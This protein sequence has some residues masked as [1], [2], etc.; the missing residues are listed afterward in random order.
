MRRS[1]RMTLAFLSPAILVASL[2]SCA[3][4]EKKSVPELPSRICWNVFASKDVTPLL[5]TGDKAMLRARPFVLAEELDSVT[6]SLDIDGAT[7][8]TA[9]ATLRDF[10]DQIDWAPIDEAKPAPINVGRKGI[11]WYDGAASY[12]VC[13]PAQSP[14]RPGRYVDLTISTDGS[15]DEEVLQKSL[16]TLMKQFVTFAQ[17]ELNCD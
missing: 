4:S 12:I 14:S 13:E 17:R 15:P 8:F 2:T 3:D 16:P 5:P 6:C 9:Y 11:I 1:R 7:K 10:E